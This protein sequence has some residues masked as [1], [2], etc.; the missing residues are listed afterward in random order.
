MRV[1]LS[2]LSKGKRTITMDLDVVAELTSLALDLDAV[3][4]EFLK[5]RAVEKTVTS[6]T[7]VVDHESVLSTSSFSRCSF[8]LTEY[9]P[10]GRDQRK[11][12]EKVTQQSG[13]GGLT[14][15]RVTC[16][17]RGGE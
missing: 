9:H 3:V 16:G 11:P 4:Q 5:G 8:D 6:R 17:C 14:I 2:D 7:G 1:N 15:L 12:T 10:E 13:T